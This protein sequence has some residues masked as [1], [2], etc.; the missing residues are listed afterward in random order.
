MSIAYEIFKKYRYKKGLEKGFETS[1]REFIAWY[2]EAKREGK[3]PEDVSITQLLR[4]HD[5]FL[6]KMLDAVDRGELRDEE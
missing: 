1:R 2:K 4:N 6:R 5:D 3:I